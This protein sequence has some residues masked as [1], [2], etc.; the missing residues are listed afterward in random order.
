MESR[1]SRQNTEG[2]RLLGVVFRYAARRGAHAV[3]DQCIVLGT[4]QR[5]IHETPLIGMQGTTTLLFLR[6]I[7]CVRLAQL[8]EEHAVVAQ[9]RAQFAIGVVLQT[10]HRIDVTQ[11][12]YRALLQARR[13]GFPASG[14]MGNFG[15]MA[16]STRIGTGTASG[17]SSQLLAVSS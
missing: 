17:L 6:Q 14:I 4:G 13:I 11:C 9:Q 7:P 12:P 1:N 5:H 10:L 3:G 8:V 15:R 2:A 16:A